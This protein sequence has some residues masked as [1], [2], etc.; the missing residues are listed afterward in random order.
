MIKLG[1][2]NQLKLGNLDARRDWCY[3]KDAVYARTDSV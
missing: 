3:A 2:T 1:L